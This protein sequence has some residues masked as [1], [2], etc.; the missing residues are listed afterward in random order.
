M[1]IISDFDG[2]IVTIDTV[3][4]LLARYA[5][6]DWRRYDDLYERGEISLEECLRRQ[7]R[8][9]KEPKQKLI[10]AIDGV[11]MFRAGFE[12]LLA[13]SREKAIPFTIVSAGLDFV[14]DHLLSRKDFRGRIV[15]LAPKSKPTS[16][17]ITLDFSGLPRG[18]SSNF[19]SVF[20]KSIKARGTGIA[21]IGDGFSDFEAVKLADARFAVKGS[22]LAEQCRKDGIECH[23][24][25]GLEE[26]VDYLDKPRVINREYA[27][28]EGDRTQV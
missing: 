17:G 9:I 18:D 2:T 28:A 6:G 25:I 26:V 14:I 5:N 1:E 19:K 3:E 16:R 20:A 23:E 13:F 11:A 12:E 7:Y 21:Y 15:V 24:I 4:Y 27:E 8:M 10:E 22:R